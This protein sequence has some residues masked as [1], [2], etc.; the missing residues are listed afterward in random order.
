VLTCFAQDA[1]TH[2]LVYAN[3]DIS[4]AAQARETLAFCDH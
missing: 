1:G 3:A 4:K 2:N